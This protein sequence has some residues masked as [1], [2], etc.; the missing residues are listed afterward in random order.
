MVFL[1][2]EFFNKQFRS[3]KMFWS[4]LQYDILSHV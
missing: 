3:I 1:M 4:A 2:A